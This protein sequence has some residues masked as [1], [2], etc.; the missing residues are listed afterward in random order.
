MLPSQQHISYRA[1]IPMR[2]LTHV[3]IVTL[4][5]EATGYQE[6]RNRKSLQLILDKEIFR[7]K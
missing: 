2:E 6:D 7:L 1:E 4:V 3:G 5:D